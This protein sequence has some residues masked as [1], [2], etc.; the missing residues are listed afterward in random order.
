MNNEFDDIFSTNTTN[1]QIEVLSVEDKPPKKKFKLD[2]KNDKV[3]MVQLIL[4][5]IW[6]LLTVIIYFFGYPLFEAFIEV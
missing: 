6:I 5:G 4:I 2:L 3:L 1:E